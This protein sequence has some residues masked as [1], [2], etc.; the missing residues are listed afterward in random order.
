[1]EI[2]KKMVYGIGIREKPRKDPD[3]PVEGEHDLLLTK[4]DWLK[5]SS[6]PL[7]PESNRR[8]EKR[9]AKSIVSDV[10]GSHMNSER[11][12]T[13]AGSRTVLTVK[14]RWIPWSTPKEV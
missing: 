3:P 9:W 7:I 10:R 13:R 1:M 6:D 4:Q 11:R 14:N 12:T 8:M 5:S 2:L